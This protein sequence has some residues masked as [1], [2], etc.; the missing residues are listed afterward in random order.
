MKATHDDYPAPPWQV[1]A[2]H[3]DEGG[4]GDFAYTV[5]LHELGHAE[6]WMAARPALGEDPGLDWRLTQRDL[7]GLL[8]DAG[9]RWL[10]GELRVGD[11]FEER[12]D[13][14]LVT[15]RFRVDPPGDRDVLEAL[16]IARDAA[17]VPI[18][19]SLHRPALQVV[20]S[21]LGEDE[22]ASAEQEFH[23][24]VDLFGAG[25]GAAAAPPGWEVPEV[26]DW[27]PVGRFGPRT[28][29]VLARANL[30]W[31][32]DDWVSDAILG[33]ALALA[34]HRPLG[35]TLAVAQTASRG[36]GR[37]RALEQVD[38][39]VPHLV[40]HLLH[41]LGAQLGEFPGD[42]VYV[43]QE[44]RHALGLLVHTSLAVEVTADRVPAGVRIAALAALPAS[45]LPPG[46][47][48]DERWRASPPV[49]ETINRLLTRLGPQGIRALAV[50][51]RHNDDVPSQQAAAQLCAL[52]VTSSC[53]WTGSG[54][55]YVPGL[56]WDADLTAAVQEWAS[57][58]AAV[59]S[60][61]AELP[62]DVVEAFAGPYLA[63]VPGLM[64]V[65]NMPV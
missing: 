40:D 21:P 34:E 18:R 59:L 14:G 61:R 42:P 46:L 33:L 60:H 1:Y 3:D 12:F 31:S 52:N 29:L 19:W 44:I 38:A 39:A 4:G 63:A 25:A 30:V 22:L 16:A 27:S 6:L 45:W 15:V 54:F 35:W 48:F 13:A 62:H 24:L 49:I 28:P 10:A 43:R 11:T 32:A 56:L 8:N 51:H 57:Y 23:R 17:V 50:A 26:P 37:A 47:P 64:E 5:G 58:V 36:A 20:P 41:R 9:R 2:I 65:L 7:C 53:S 55:P